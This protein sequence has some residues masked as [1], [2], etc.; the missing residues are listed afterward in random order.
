M[1]HE[2]LQECIRSLAMMDETDSFLI[3]CYLNLEKSS[4]GCREFLRGTGVD[5]GKKRAGRV[6]EQL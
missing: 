4:A 1:V 6:A 2:D 3:S 5:A